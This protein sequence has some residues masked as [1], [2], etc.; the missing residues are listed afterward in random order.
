MPS[1]CSVPEI[2]QSR[3][4]LWQEAE[5]VSGRREAISEQRRGECSGEMR[6]HSDEWKAKTPGLP[7]LHQ[8]FHLGARL[9]ARERD[10]L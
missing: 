5:M 1:S 10:L 6:A 8:C 3:V 7:Y 4:E 9:K 2:E